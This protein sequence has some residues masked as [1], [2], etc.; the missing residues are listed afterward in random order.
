[1]A[2][3]SP[4]SRFCVADGHQVICQHAPCFRVIRLQ[5]HCALQRIDGFIPMTGSC[6]CLGVF[7]MCG[8]PPW[9]RND[10]WYDDL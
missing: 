7:E 3:I 6:K 5:P 1:M 8:N 4:V 2:C 10:Q 9:L